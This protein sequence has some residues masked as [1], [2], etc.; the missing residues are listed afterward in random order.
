MDALIR[1]C[2]SDVIRNTVSR[3]PCRRRFAM[4]VATRP[5]SSRPHQTCVGSIAHRRVSEAGAI[6][7][8]LSSVSA[9][10]TV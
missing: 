8:V 1:A 10:K 5:Q 6:A 4:I 3:S 2:A 9:E 7:T